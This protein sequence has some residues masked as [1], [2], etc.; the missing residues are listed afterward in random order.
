MKYSPINGQHKRR[1][2]RVTSV[3]KSSSTLVLPASSTRNRRRFFPRAVP[4]FLSHGRAPPNSYQC[5]TAVH[6]RRGKS[7]ASERAIGGDGGTRANG[8]PALL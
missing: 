5:L 7:I 1:G 3:R 4:R 2:E 6:K 8:A